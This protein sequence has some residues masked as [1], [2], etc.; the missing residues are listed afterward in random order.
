MEFICTVRPLFQEATVTV[1]I[2]VVSE[3]GCQ[4]RVYSASQPL[5]SGPHSLPAGIKN[6]SS[7]K[8]ATQSPT[9]FR[10]LPYIK[11]IFTSQ[12]LR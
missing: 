3:S 1:L 11:V 4:T 8:R 5:V 12:D 6:L 2:G 9:I 10:D 7:L